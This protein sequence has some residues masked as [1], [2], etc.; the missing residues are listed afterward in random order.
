MLLK[1]LKTQSTSLP[2]YC[3]EQLI[4]GLFS[5]VSS[6]L[7]IILRSFFYKLVISAKSFPVF[8]QGI[9]IKQAKYLTLGK[10]VFIDS[11]V[12]LHGGKNGINIGNNSRIM[13]QAEL[14]VYNFRNLKNSKINIGDNCVVGPYS[15]ITGQFGVDIGD[16]VIIAPR[17][18]ILPINHNYQKTTI[19]IAEQGILGK[20]IKIKNNVWIGAHAVILD[21]VTINEGSVIAAGSVVKNDVP[22]YSLVGGVPAKILKQW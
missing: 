21:G 15:I 4:F 14:N 5:R 10:N 1:F 6:I 20:G 7:G 18:S 8:E 22:K 13:H 11:N 19:T 16:N 12:Y 9:I 2:R 17:V 3:L